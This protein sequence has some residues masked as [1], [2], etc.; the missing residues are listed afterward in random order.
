MKKE[1]I[2]IKAAYM[3]PEI[4]VHEV[5][6]QQSFMSG[7]SSISDAEEEDWNLIS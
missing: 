7:E 6:A 1:T 3:A 4:R 5:R 2:E